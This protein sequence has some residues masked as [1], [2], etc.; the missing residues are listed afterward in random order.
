MQTLF[1]SLSPNESNE[2]ANSKIFL[3]YSKIILISRHS[4]ELYSEIELE[5]NYTYY[6]KETPEEIL[7]L[8]EHKE[9]IKLIEHKNF[10]N[11]N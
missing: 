7:K 6:V 2:K 3:N 10:T 5:D 1:I 11:R 9:L 8:I 4:S